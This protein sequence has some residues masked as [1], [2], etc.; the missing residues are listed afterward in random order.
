MLPQLIV[1]VRRNP[2]PSNVQEN[3]NVTWLDYV[4]GLKWIIMPLKYPAVAQGILKITCML[5]GGWLHWIKERHR[6]GEEIQPKLY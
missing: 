1:N 3:M 4:H 2:N 5:W 6:I